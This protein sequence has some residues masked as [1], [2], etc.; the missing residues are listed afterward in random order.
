[1]M[2]AIISLVSGFVG[3]VI[4]AAGAVLTVLINE[5]YQKR[6]ERIRFAVELATRDYELALENSKR[7]SGTVRVY[8]LTSYLLYHHRLLLAL[9]KADVKPEDI[10]EIF[11]EHTRIDK[12]IDESQ[13]NE[14]PQNERPLP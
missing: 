9:E 11:Q 7:L 10:R 8:P 4:G 1:M 3:A 12:I 13:R 5:H 14:G 6:R 2:T